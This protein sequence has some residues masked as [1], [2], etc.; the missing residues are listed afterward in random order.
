MS[1]SQLDE[2]KIKIKQSN[3]TYKNKGNKH[4][5]ELWKMFDE[6]EDKLECIYFSVFF[7]VF[8]VRY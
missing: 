7:L 5:K 2:V 8:I 6:V 4:K 1:L 3:G